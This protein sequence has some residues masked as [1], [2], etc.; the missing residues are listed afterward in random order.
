M[1]KINPKSMLLIIATRGLILISN[2]T[3]PKWQ[4]KHKCENFEFNSACYS[5]EVIVACL[6]V[7]HRQN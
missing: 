6:M 4:K 2:E 3:E 5:R 1:M 7:S